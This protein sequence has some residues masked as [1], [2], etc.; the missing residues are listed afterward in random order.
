MKKVELI[1]GIESSVLGFG[2]APIMGAVGGKKGRNAI[3]CAIDNGVNHFDLARSYGFGEAEKFVGQIIKNKRDKVILASK[4]GIKANCKAKVL[5]PF[6]PL[7]REILEFKKSIYKTDNSLGLK[8]DNNNFKADRFH[9]RIELNVN[10]MKISL[11]ESLKA[12]G[13][14]YLDY[15]FIHEPIDSIDNIDDLIYLSEKL[16]KEGK[17]RA[18]GLTFMQNQRY[19][20]ESYLN[21]FDLL[22]FNNS[23]GLETYDKIVEERGHKSNIFFS[24]IN[25]GKVNISVV[26][27]LTKLH[28]DFSK[29]VIL[30]SMFNEKHI[31]NNSKLFNE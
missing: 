21:K 22:Q 20:H 18:F 26:D 28:K 19:L 12:L 2:C 24:P 27:K 7:V 30:C 17:I 16:K 5:V 9:N 6:K 3:E 23:P 4:F 1:K 14:D 11:E 13:T 8:N 29:S 31:I 15:F 25:G 10:E